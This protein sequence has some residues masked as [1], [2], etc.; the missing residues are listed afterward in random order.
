VSVACRC[1]VSDSCRL[2]PGSPRRWDPEAAWISFDRMSDG[3]DHE[4]P[5]VLMRGGTSKGVFVHEADLPPAG[6]DRDSFILALMGTPDP[7]QIDGLGGTHSSTSKLV[8]VS[9][10][11]LD[12]CDV[13]YL[14]VQVGI[15]R[16]IVDYAGNCG[17]LTSAVGAFAI[18]EG[19]VR[20]TEPVTTVRLHNVN[21]GK[22]IL[23]HTPVVAGRAA[24][25]APTRLAGVPGTGTE[26]RT[27]Y[28]DPSGAV[29]GHLL[30]T[31]R[32]RTLLHPRT[33]TPIEVSIVDVTAPVV[34]AHLAD[35][36]LDPALDIDAANAQ[37]ALLQRLESLRAEAAVVLGLAPDAAAA[38]AV[39]PAV[40]RVVLVGGPP[41]GEPG[42]ELVVRATSLQRVH[43]ACPLTSALCTAAAAAIPGSVPASV[44]SLPSGGTIRLV[45]PKGVIEV[46]VKTGS[47]MEGTFIS[48][49]S[50]ARTARRLLRG[51]AY[52]RRSGPTSPAP[53]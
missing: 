18:D 9:P 28:M 22:R 15:E 39:S 29:T 23:A 50:V 47:N 13:D 46:E 43:H 45:H 12:D 4:I 16:P 34:I 42:H 36:G 14:F 8:A 30:P 3:P 49:V 24:T 26:L 44:S 6:E 1:Y 35:V 37:P 33:G 31:G 25:S 52:V 38:A 41:G 11:D 21:T 2:M 32:P 5:V 48:S 53:R 19:L 27:E 10:S 20:A 51:T 7:M 40:P 17:N